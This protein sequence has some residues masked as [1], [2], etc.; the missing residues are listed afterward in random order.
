M[1]VLLLAL[2][3]GYALGSLPS[4]A[5]VAGIKGERIFEVGSGNMGTMN[6]ARNLG[7]GL[8]ALVLV[9]DV[10]KGALAGVLGLWLASLADTP[11]WALTPHAAGLGAVVGH[12]W[13][14]WVGFRG[15]KALATTLG[16]ALVL[17][18]LVG[19]VGLGLLVVFVVL[20]RR[21]ALSSMGLAALYPFVAYA[22]LVARSVP[23][24]TLL[25][26]VVGV[27]AIALVVFVKHLLALGEER[28]R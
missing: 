17:Y 24:A 9:M 11:P 5:L 18:P 20:S 4:A 15:G 27:S 10:G 23:R 2:L 19:L 12:A 7:W 6:T 13:S 28:R 16:V 1:I 14:V 25:A 21:V 3:A 22:V 26:T 8:G